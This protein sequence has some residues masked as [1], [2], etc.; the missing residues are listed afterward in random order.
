M[1][2]AKKAD[3]LKTAVKAALIEVLDERQDL[4]FQA[5]REAMEDIGLAHAMDEADRKTVGRDKIDRLLKRG[6]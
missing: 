5:V 6:R 3:D 1:K 2:V 4:L